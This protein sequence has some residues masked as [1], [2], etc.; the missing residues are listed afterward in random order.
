MSEAATTKA[1]RPW[2]GIVLATLDRPERL[3]ALT[4]AMFEEIGALCA[5]VAEDEEARALIIT[6]AGR[7]FC[8]GLD[9]DAATLGQTI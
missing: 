7:G 5:E 9:L 1:E 6:G 4:L 2:P 3:N 8:A